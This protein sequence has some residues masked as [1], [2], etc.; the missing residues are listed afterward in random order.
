MTGINERKHKAELCNKTEKK[1]HGERLLVLSRLLRGRYVSVTWTKMGV[2][3]PSHRT[4]RGKHLVQLHNCGLRK[5]T[6]VIYTNA[7]PNGK[8]TWCKDLKM[9]RDG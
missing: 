6:M 9:M 7:V 2:I 8:V 5:L 1:V 3:T 4:I